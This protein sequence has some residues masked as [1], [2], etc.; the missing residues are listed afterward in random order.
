MDKKLNNKFEENN[1]SL[2]INLCWLVSPD[3]ANKFE[4]KIKESND[5][6]KHIIDCVAITPKNINVNKN[7]YSFDVRWSVTK[8]IE[9]SE[10]LVNQVINN[11]YEVIKFVDWDRFLNDKES[12]YKN[13]VDLLSKGKTLVVKA[14]D[15]GLKSVNTKMFLDVLCLKRK[16]ENEN[17]TI[18]DVT[19]TAIDME[20]FDKFEKELMNNE[21]KK[22][23]VIERIR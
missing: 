19:K 18:K 21:R 7:R 23:K 9:T 4:K 15:V 14:N 3:F 13:S 8:P 16:I 20:K 2:L 6:A 5:Y 11:K 22:Y 12:I 17:Y 1:E 10:G